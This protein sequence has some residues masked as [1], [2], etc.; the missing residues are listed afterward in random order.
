MRKNKVKIMAVAAMART[1]CVT[2]SRIISRPPLLDHLHA[3]LPVNI[4]LCASRDKLPLVR[5]PPPRRSSR[6]HKALAAIRKGLHS[7][8][9][10]NRGRVGNDNR[11][12][13][14]SSA[15]SFFRLGEVV[16]KAQTDHQAKL[17]VLHLFIA[18]LADVVIQPQLVHS[19][20]LLTE[21]SGFL[22][23]PSSIDVNVGLHGLLLPR[24]QID[25]L[26]SGGVFVV[27]V[28]AHN[29]GR[30]ASVLLAPNLIASGIN[31]VDL[32]TIK[33]TVHVKIS[34]QNSSGP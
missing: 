33:H 17:D 3:Q 30:A 1:L 26:Q 14:I 5:M 10:R 13:N 12:N 21:G 4:A 34:L 29:D 6:L 18:Q 32:A 2:S 15:R 23:L 9:D 31:I 28:V 20:N 11:A 19:K 24:G 7:I 22:Q 25:D 27:M 8:I 16:V